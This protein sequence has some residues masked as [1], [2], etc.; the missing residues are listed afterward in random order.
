MN[1]ILVILVIV[2][3]P[4]III[5]QIN[6]E[7][8]FDNFEPEWQK[9]VIDSSS[10]SST[11]DG[12]D[13]FYF[14]YF[15]L[16]KDS[17]L[18]YISTFGKKYDGVYLE[19]FNNRTGEKIW[20]NYFINGKNNDKSE[21]LSK[22]YIDS[23]YV[24]ILCHRNKDEDIFL[25]NRSKFSH[26][27][28]NKISGDIVEHLYTDFNDTL[29]PTFF[30][31]FGSFTFLRKI[32]DNK[33]MYA[34]YHYRNAPDSFDYIIYMMDEMGYNP[35]KYLINGL[36]KDR[37]EVYKVLLDVKHLG[38]DTLIFFRANHDTDPYKYFT[39]EIN[40]YVDL[41]DV[42]INHLST[43][44]IDGLDYKRTKY[45][46]VIL[47]YVDKDLFVISTEDGENSRCYF[48]DFKGNLLKK[49]N[50]Q[51][52]DGARLFLPH[53]LR[54]KDGS[55]LIVGTTYTTTKN[56]YN[57]LEF[58][59][60]DMKK[61]EII[62][63]KKL[64]IKE[65]NQYLDIRNFIELDNENIVVQGIH[66]YNVYDSGGYFKKSTG[67][68]QDIICFDA[69]SLGLKTS[70]TD[71]VKLSNKIKLYPNPANSVLNIELKDKIF[72]KAEIKNILGQKVLSQAISGE[73]TE[74][75]DISGLLPGMYFVSIL[76]DKG[77]V[78]GT[79]K[80]LKE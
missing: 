39:A 30:T 20:S 14:P 56:K 42:D 65:V 70:T 13:L 50:L 63:L 78:C 74:E 57:S 4:N 32:N 73:R 45:S 60:L 47:K 75:V 61:D 17:V 7:I 46:E 21:W 27:K 2:L 16:N 66:R 64:K 6:P 55:F 48:Y 69:A 31:H 35:E 68:W 41:F 25:N 76:N 10:I 19:K 67:Y 40:F 15:L 62:P 12:M 36:S 5:S 1:K 79:A 71:M 26:W 11:S 37:E 49:I 59:K 51:S 72:G 54:L 77:I 43:I 80:F 28:F 18:Y 22:A 24:E 9:V 58:L 3:F 52:V 34:T 33:F 8:K 29:S 44:K 53:I 23:E 38:N